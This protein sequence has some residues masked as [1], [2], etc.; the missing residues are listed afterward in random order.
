MYWFY[1]QKDEIKLRFA[2]RP[3]VSEIQVSGGHLGFR[4]LDFQVVKMAKG[5]LY[6]LILYPEGRI[7]APFCSTA[8]R[9][10]DAGERRPS[11]IS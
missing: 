7:K 11:W 4:D 10:R 6:V 3:A 1:I 5:D 2:L 9:F 8:S